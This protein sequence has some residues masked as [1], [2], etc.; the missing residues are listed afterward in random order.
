MAVR[1]DQL[2]RGSIIGGYRIDE[3][4]GRGGMGLVYRATNVALNRIYA[5]KVLAPG[6]AE[7]EGFR[8]RFKREMRIA[9]SLHHPNIVGIHYAGEQDGMLFFVMDYV[10]GTD[11][12][13]ILMKQG[14]LDPNR[15][16]DLLDQFASALDAAHRRG[17]VHRDVKPG[18]IMITVKDGEEHAYLT[19]FGLAKKFDTV[20]GLT[21]KG[22]IVGTVDYMAPE[23]ITGSRTD[24]RTD[25]YALG[26]V[27]YQMLNGRVPYERDNSVAT[28]YAHVHEPPPP[29]EGGVSDTH[30]AFAPVFEKAMAKESDDRYFS[31][32]DF[33][34]DAAAALRGTRD[35]APPTI[36]ATGEATPLVLATVEPAPATPI[37]DEPLGREVTSAD[38][39]ATSAPAAADDATKLA[40]TDDATKLAAPDDATKLGAPDEAA[41]RT[42]P[43]APP[44]GAGDDA[45]VDDPYET[46]AS[47]AVP[48]PETKSPGAA[49]PEPPRESTPPAT[50]E[51]EPPRETMPPATTEPE[52]PRETMPPATTEP[53]PPR[54]TMP[55]ATTEPEPPRETMPPVAPDEG[56]SEV[57]RPAGIAA[58]AAAASSEQARPSSP[59]SSHQAPPSIPPSVQQPPPSTPPSVQ[60]PPSAPPPTSGA[61]GASGPTEPPKKRSRL[62]IFAGLALIVAAAIVVIVLVSGGGSSTPKGEPFSAAAKPVP[63]NRVTG[64]GSAT[65]H[66]NGDVVS[67]TVDTNG[68]LNGQPHAMHIHAG[69]KGLCPPASAARLHNGNRAISTTNGIPYY[70][71]PR[72]SLTTTGDTSPDSRVALPRYPRVGDIRYTRAVT[73]P[74]G[75]AA[76]IRAGDAVIVVHGIDYD[77][78]GIYDNILDRS[79][80]DS[81]LP[82]EATAP[83]LCGT[84]VPTKNAS[85]SGGTTYAVTFHRTVVAAVA[86]GS[87]FALLCHLIGVDTTVLS[88]RRVA[89]TTAT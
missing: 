55:P 76:A 71:P 67:V 37:E 69:G 65:V 31:A 85:V 52:P 88:D 61:G 20:S 42:A 78:N 49:E 1:G 36:V 66:L 27:F 9:A 83:A 45:E 44:T 38:P 10:T 57:I 35:M 89:G 54:E 24:A 19:D 59:P 56:G 82:G 7:D 81:S 63:T 29:L 17:L 16:V 6:L 73:V 58:A 11:L 40:A 33:A 32:G 13:E 84:L 5:L 80:L 8:Q 26:C 43:P 15:A 14:A 4:I 50:T 48:P 68:L 77:H 62:P 86:Q 2:G 74:T 60:Q 22:S 39:D 30:P 21:S 25:I 53:E 41:E 28:L 46:I 51:P 70:G 18:N 87:S 47:S 12:R 64:D 34:R 3:L 79:E 23:Q 75:V 72:V